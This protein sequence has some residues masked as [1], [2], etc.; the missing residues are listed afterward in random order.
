MKIKPADRLKSVSEYY[1]SKKLKEIADMNARGLDV[2][3]LGIGSPDMAPSENTVEMLVRESRKKDTHA[4]QS[5]SGI[6]ALREAFAQWYRKYFLVTLNPDK[7]ILPLMGSKEGIMHISMAFLNPG[8]EVLIPNPG[9]PAYAAVSRL[10]NANIRHYELKEENNWLPDL[11][12]LEKTDLSDV[13]LMWINYPNMPTG[14]RATKQL[15][16]GLIDFGRRNNILIINDNPYSFILNEEHLSLLSIPG[17]EEVALEMNSLSKSHNMAGWRIGM[18]AGHQEYLQFILKVK[19]NMDSGMFKPLQMAAAR[20]L[21]EDDDWFADINRVYKARQKHIFR[22]LDY[23]K[24]SYDPNQTGMFVWAKIPAG[25]TG[26]ED[27]SNR[28]LSESAVFITPGFIFGSC[29]EGYIR[30]SLCAEEARLKEAE[31]RIK[32]TFSKTSIGTRLQR[33]PW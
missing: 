15:F 12:A 20:A 7:E 10:V 18:V 14:A 8:D 2:I 4:Y 17:A 33:V 3:N 26:S 16:K 29:G 28:I 30:L 5:Y 9:Y 13:K 6:P 23:L 24:C 11:E 22:L 19:S 32:K 21:Q 25:S 31:S 27:F 1:F